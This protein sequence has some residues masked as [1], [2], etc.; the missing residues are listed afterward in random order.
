[1]ELV[2]LLEGTLSGM[3][4]DLI[5]VERSNSGRLLRVFI[6]KSDGITV[7]D[8]ALVS[9]QLSRLLEVE[10]VDY[11]RLEISSPGLDR[12]LRGE[13]DFKRFEGEK[14]MVR[15]RVPIE[16]QRNFVG[17]LREADAQTLRIE[18]DGVLVSIPMV[19]IEKARLIPQF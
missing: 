8:C 5:D 19:S 11:D 4:Y 16:G 2:E 18:V 10:A 12:P 6:D 13:R 3:G 15:V 14:A 17:I 9:N 1:M 7:D